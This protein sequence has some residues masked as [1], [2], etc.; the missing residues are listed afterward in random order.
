MNL[1]VSPTEENPVDGRAAVELFQL[2]EVDYDEARFARELVVLAGDRFHNLCRQLT[3]PT[4]AIP[5]RRFPDGPDHARLM[6]WLDR[7]KALRFAGWYL[8][9]LVPPLLLVGLAARYNEFLGIVVLVAAA[10]VIVAGTAKIWVTSGDCRG[11]ADGEAAI[12]GADLVNGIAGVH[13]RTNLYSGSVNVLR[14]GLL[15]GFGRAWLL[16]SP[17]HKG[18]QVADLLLS[19]PRTGQL[20]SEE[21]LRAL[22][23]VLGASSQES[24]RAAGRQLEELAAQAPRS[25]MLPSITESGDP[26]FSVY[27]YVLWLAVKGVGRAIVLL[28]V[29]FTVAMAGG[30]AGEGSALVGP[31]LFI[32]AACLFGVWVC[33]ALYRTIGL[34][35]ALLGFAVRALRA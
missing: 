20:R 13:H 28:G 30:M 31:A 12:D 2:N 8:F 10:V 25:A 5:L 6:R 16:A 3:R 35:D 29:V 17:G 23:A 24:D 14:S 21:D 4:R 32:I 11:L 18:H 9:V 22:V 34:L 19:D 7:Q 15:K 1:G 26:P 27:M 33:Y